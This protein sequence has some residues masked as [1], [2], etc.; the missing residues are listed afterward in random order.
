MVMAKPGRPVQEEPAK[1]SAARTKRHLKG[2][3]PSQLIFSGQGGQPFFVFF[4]LGRD[5]F[6]LKQKKH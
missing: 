6:F 4:C 5:L 2:A 3:R 1:V